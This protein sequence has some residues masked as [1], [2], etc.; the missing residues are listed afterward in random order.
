MPI[1]LSIVASEIILSVASFH[2]FRVDFKIFVSVILTNF[3]KDVVHQSEHFY[4]PCATCIE[5][6]YYFVKH[7]SF[8]NSSTGILC[9]KNKSMFPCTKVVFICLINKKIVKYSIESNYI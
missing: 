2:Q 4:M 7:S 8:T 1:Y 5:I 3:E 6:Y 9:M